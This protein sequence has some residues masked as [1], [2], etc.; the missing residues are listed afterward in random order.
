MTLDEALRPHGLADLGGL[1]PEAGGTLVLIG[2]AGP[3]FW[4]VF[5]AAPEAQDGAP[6]PLDRWS[7]RILDGVAAALDARAIYPFDG[8]PWPPFPAWALASGWCHTSPVGLLVHAEAGLW[9]SFRG[10]LLFAEVLPLPAPPP[11]PC[12]GCADQPCR[13][14][15]PVD[16]FA[17]G[18]DEAA[19][20]RHLD[21]P[22]GAPCMA[23]GCAVRAACPVSRAHGREPAQS[24]FHMRAFHR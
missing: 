12:A 19:C 20:H 14:A 4:P 7:R 5:R 10:A 15:C 2:P 3:G 24:A 18:Y 1:H 9:V 17:E 13:R 16:A 11:S 6:D 22:D 8:P 21:R 23:R